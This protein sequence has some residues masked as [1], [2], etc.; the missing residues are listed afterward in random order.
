[1]PSVE[2]A[3]FKDFRVRNAIH[4]ATDRANIDDGLY[5]PGWAYQS[6]LSP[7]YP[8]AWG[9][10]KVNFQVTAV[11][12]ERYNGG[13]GD[14]RK[15]IMGRVSVRVLDT[16]DSSRVGGLRVTGYGQYGKP[17]T[18]GARQRWLGMVSYR[19]KQIT[20]A[21]EAA[22]TRDSVTAGTTSRQTA[23]AGSQENAL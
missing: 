3:P 1:M 9:P 13:T 5:G 4:L 10:D 15:D 20:L 11:N 23:P 22:L 21:G 14:Q 12:G 2:Y 8:E 18:G 7:G 19:T 6:A 16:D 17:N